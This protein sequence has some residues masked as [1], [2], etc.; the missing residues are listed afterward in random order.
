MA[1]ALFLGACASPRNS[2]E[3]IRV[4]VSADGKTLAVQ[5]AAGSSVQQA[6]S[7]ANLSLGA[8]DRTDPPIYSVLSAGQSV[9][10]VRVTEKFEVIHEAIPF[11]NQTLYN[12]SLPEGKDNEVYI[13]EGKNGKREV[14]TRQVFEDGV[15]VS[16]SEVKSTVIEQPVAAIWMKGIQRPFTPVA[17]PGRL[18]YLR[19]GNAWMIEATT[20]NRRAVVTTGDLD[21]YIFSLS[22]DGTWLLFTRKSKAEGQINSLWA[23]RIG[24]PKT[25]GTPAGLVDLK[26][27]NV[28]YFADWLPG[29]S[30]QA[31]YSTVEPQVAAPGWRTNNDL[32]NV[33][34][35]KSKETYTSTVQLR[36]NLG[37]VYPWWGISFAWANDTLRLAYANDHAVGILDVNSAK[38]SLQEKGLSSWLEFAPLKTYSDWAWVPGVSWGP[39]GKMLYSVNHFAPPGMALPEESQLFDLAAIPLEGGPAVSLASDVGM[40]AYPVPS[41]VQVQPSGEQAYQVAYLQA[42]LPHESATSHYQVCVMDRDGSNKRALFPEAGMVGLKPQREWGDWSPAPLPG[43]SNF[44]IATIYEGNLWLVDA[45]AGSDGCK[46]GQSPANEK[47]QAWQITGDG[48]TTRVAWK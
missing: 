13:Q 46:P 33:T 5:V 15:E 38:N 42:A 45:S 21:G 22:D 40:F 47:V 24:D 48:Q 8:L 9:R 41:P 3:Q 2:Q 34:I 30:A 10:L 25:D 14:V 39:D 1:I 6:L 28:I 11:E 4:D 27:K 17:V 43:S 23:A 26:I 7:A 35:F 29:S 16:R 32:R 44:A 36:E 20:G 12:E 18:V 37:G 19:D 31:A